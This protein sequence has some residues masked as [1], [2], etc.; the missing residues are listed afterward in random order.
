MKKFF[1]K[2]K[3]GFGKAV[4][5]IKSTFSSVKTRI[6]KAFQNLKLKIKKNRED[7][8]KTQKEKNNKMYTICPARKDTSPANRKPSFFESSNTS[9]AHP[10]SNAMISRSWI[11]LFITLERYI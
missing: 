7:K 10:D 2:I 9:P 6:S 11:S 3:D 5:K 1:S 8:V 4:N